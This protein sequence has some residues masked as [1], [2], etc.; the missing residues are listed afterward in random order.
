MKEV[1]ILYN[2]NF[3]T[4]KDYNNQIFLHA[5]EFLTI[6]HLVEGKG[7]NFKKR[8]EFKKRANDRNKYLTYSQQITPNIAF[9]GELVISEDNIITGNISYQILKPNTTHIIE[10]YYITISQCNYFIEHIITNQIKRE[11]TEE[12]LI[13]PL[14]TFNIESFLFNILN[15]INNSHSIKN[16][17]LIPISFYINKILTEEQSILDYIKTLINKY[18]ELKAFLYFYE[19]PLTR[20]LTSPK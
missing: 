3:L 15:K 16:K 6:I 8:I 18:P 13:T 2:G 17:I 10:G 9:S 7:N 1:S 14:S 11:S 19:K 5:D 4:R 12:R 20:K